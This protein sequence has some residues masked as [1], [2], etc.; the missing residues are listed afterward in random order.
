MEIYNNEEQQVEA[1]KRFWKQNG[2][3]ILAGIAIGL[4]GLYGFRAYQD[5]QLAQIEA[6]SSQYAKLIEQ[7]QCRRR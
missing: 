5:N 6:Q 3:S 2:T 1:I 4:A 7:N